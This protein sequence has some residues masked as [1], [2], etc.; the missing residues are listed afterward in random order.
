MLQWIVANVGINKQGDKND[1]IEHRR[2]KTDRRMHNA[3]K[4]VVEAKMFI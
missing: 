3:M 2:T 4:K 1:L